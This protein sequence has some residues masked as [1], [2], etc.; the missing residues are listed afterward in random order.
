MAIPAISS[1]ECLLM[2]AAGIFG[3]LDQVGKDLHGTTSNWN[4]DVCYSSSSAGEKDFYEH[5]VL[6]SVPDFSLCYGTL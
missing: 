2:R 4:L 3:S 5:A 6:T 1:M